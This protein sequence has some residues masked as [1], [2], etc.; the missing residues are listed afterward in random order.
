MAEVQGFQ[1]DAAPLQ[2]HGWG[3][4]AS[5]GAVYRPGHWFSPARQIPVSVGPTGATYLT[6]F[7]EMRGAYIAVAP[8][9]AHFEEFAAKN[10][11]AVHECPARSADEMRS[12]RVPALLIFGDRDFSPLPDVL[13]TYELLPNA[14]LAVL[15]G[16][17]HMSVARRSGEV[18]GLITPFLDIR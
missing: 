18:L 13:E 12:L 14:Q 6:D 1:L 2:G 16:A 15:P 4:V 5:L 3:H 17:T 9:P 10:A 8:D 11:K 7:E